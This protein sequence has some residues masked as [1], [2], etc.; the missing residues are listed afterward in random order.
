MRGLFSILPYSRIAKHLIRNVLF[1]AILTIILFIIIT[2]LITWFKETKE[3]KNKFDEIQNSY[4]DV[5]RETLWVDDNDSLKVILLGICRLPGVQYAD[6]HSKDVQICNAGNK[7]SSMKLSRKFSIVHTYNGKT[8]TLGVLHIV[9][10]L[11]YVKQK[12]SKA[13]LA[14]T[15]SQT[16]I[17]LIACIVILFL[18]YRMVIGPLLKITNYTSALSLDAIGTP[19]VFNQNAQQNN[20]LDDLAV[21]INYMQKNMYHAFSRQKKVEDQLNEH[22]ENLE[23]IVEQ[24]TEALN[25]INEKLRLEIDERKRAEIALKKSETNLKRAQGVGQMGSW[26]LDLTTKDLEWSEEAY[27]LFNVSKKEPITFDRFLSVIHPDDLNFV[28]DSWAAALNRAPYDI[29]HRIIVNGSEK[30]V[31]EIAEVKFDQNEIPLSGIGIVQDI[32]ERKRIEAEREKLII[33]LKEAIENIKTLS[34][35]IP[36]CASCKKIRDDQGYWNVLESYIQKHSEVSFSHSMCPECSDKFY[37]DQDWYIKR[38][39][40]KKE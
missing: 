30:W 2:G 21:A 29:E 18:I 31:R 3:I 33:E 25:S 34:G 7:P 19:L 26:H 15:L 16:S 22:R 38:K 35:L 5:I 32:T 12:I 39:K 24:R 11:N 17:I 36:I 8:Y 6:I 4:S 14:T 27:R 23:K 9:G 20:E 10:D 37:G 28:S 13:I 1:F 40:K